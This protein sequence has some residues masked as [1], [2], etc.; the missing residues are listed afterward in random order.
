MIFGDYIPNESNIEESVFYL[1]QN[2]AFEYKYLLDNQ[3]CVYNLEINSRKLDEH[4]CLILK[5]DVGLMTYIVLDELNNNQ[6]FFLSNSS[7]NPHRH[8]RE[9]YNAQNN[10]YESLSMKRSC[11]ERFFW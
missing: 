11:L 6:V 7:T 2:T 3:E 5:F 8:T 4:N 1:L 10:G 9:E